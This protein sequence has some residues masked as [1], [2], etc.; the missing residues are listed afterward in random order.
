MTDGST[1]DK[2]EDILTCVTTLTGAGICIYDLEELFS[3]ERAV[4][5]ALRGHYCDFCYQF[6]ALPGGKPACIKSDVEDAVSIAKEYH[7]PFFHTCHIGLT[8]LVLPIFLEEKL[9]AAVF[10]GQC[11]IDGE[12]KPDIIYQ[13][14]KKFGMGRGQFDS[15]FTSLPLCSRHKLHSAGR[16]A[17]SAFQNLIREGGYDSLQAYFDSGDSITQAIRYVENH[18]L[19]ELST[20]MVAEQVHLNP[21]YLARQ[22]KYRLGYGITEYIRILR[23]KRAKELLHRTSLPVR[24]IAENAGYP[25]QAYFT[26]CFTRQVGCSPASFRQKIREEKRNTK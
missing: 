2:V 3:G 14:V 19:E 7:S 20:H 13:N 23:M 1:A 8:E 4:V 18:Y 9:I 16:L 25:D 21:S 22:F 11:R 10:I 26:R 24:V 17:E 6:R 12:T 5:R 15:L